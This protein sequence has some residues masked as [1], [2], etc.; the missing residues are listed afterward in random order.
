MKKSVVGKTIVLVLTAFILTGSAQATNYTEVKE[1]AHSIAEQARAIG[2]SEEHPIIIGAKQLWEDTE[3]QYQFD[4]Q[5]MATVIFNE[6]GYCSDEIKEGIGSVVIN[7]VNSDRWPNTVYDVV[8]APRQY[9]VAYATPGSWL[10]ERARTEV[11]AES[12]ASCLEI[13]FRVLNGEVD[14][15]TN[16]V[17]QANF[18]Q[19]TG[20]WKKMWSAEA[21]SWTYFCYE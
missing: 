17:Y 8:T 10:W 14:V 3:A 19:G 2:L 7:R 15:P 20:V 5:I 1:T 18:A 12:F 13:A 16:V 9:L 21:R 6:G 11:N 4:A